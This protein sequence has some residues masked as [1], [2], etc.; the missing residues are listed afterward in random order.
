MASCHLCAS[1]RQLAALAS[2]AIQQL[3][4]CMVQKNLLFLMQL[5]ICI[6]PLLKGKGCICQARRLAEVLRKTVRCEVD[7]KERN[8]SWMLGEVR[9]RQVPAKR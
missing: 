1:I 5:C 3:S 4:G 7:I 8:E 2:A 9:T 6:K